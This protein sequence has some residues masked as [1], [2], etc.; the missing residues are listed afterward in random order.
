M[1]RRGPQPTPTQILAA[2]G[3]RRAKAR[4][5]D[6]EAAAI[7]SLDAELRKPRDLTGEAAAIW[8]EL[9]PILRNLGVLSD[10]DG[11]TIAR[12]CATMAE[13]RALDRIIATEGRTYR[14]EGGQFCPHPCVR[15]RAERAKEAQ[16][17]EDRFGLSPSAR[18]SLHIV[19]AAALKAQQDAKAKKDPKPGKVLDASR[20]FTKS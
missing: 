2:A 18:T 15:M 3:D 13:W 12:Y 20:F 14:T 17:F 5:R 16:G 9:I 19:R 7:S 8:D 4:M 6:G 11:M 1:G 10:S